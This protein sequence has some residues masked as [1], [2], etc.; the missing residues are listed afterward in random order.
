M[1]VLNRYGIPHGVRGR[2]RARRSKEEPNAVDC[3]R[4]KHLDGSKQLICGFKPSTP[5]LKITVKYR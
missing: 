3:E 4:G 1:R 2:E 5:T